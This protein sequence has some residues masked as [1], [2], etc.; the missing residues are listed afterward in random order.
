H[1][2]GGS[3]E[4]GLAA[5]AAAAA[6]ACCCCCWLLLLLAA[7]LLTDWAVS[8][9]RRHCVA[10]TARSS[11]AAVVVVLILVE[12]RRAFAR[13]A[14]AGAR[15]CQSAA[16][17]LKLIKHPTPPDRRRQHPQSAVK[18]SQQ[19]HTV[20]ESE[21]SVTASQAAAAMGDVVQFT[22]VWLRDF[23]TRLDK[24]RGYVARFGASAARKRRYTDSGSALTNTRFGKA[25]LHRFGR[26]EA[27]RLRQIRTRRATPD[28]GEARLRQIRKRGYAR[29]RLRKR[30]TPDSREARYRQIREARLRADSGR[31]RYAD[32]HQIREKRGYDRFATNQLLVSEEPSM[33]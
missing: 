24:R 11:A 6:D 21:H 29:A 5:A 2:P 20:A 33:Y 12:V 31:A 9:A 30:A 18:P 16:D 22:A 19:P 28:S 15:A 3:V 26:A 1:G 32:L 4:I 8:P 13:R 23:G 14:T 10:R 17:P 27:K 7:A 25:R